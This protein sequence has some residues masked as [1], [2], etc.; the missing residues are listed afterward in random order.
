MAEG[1]AAEG[2]GQAH[3]AQAEESM[4]LLDTDHVTVLRY[5]GHPRCSTL[6]DRLREARQPAATTIVTLEEQMRGWLAE[7][8][9]WREVAKQVTAYERLADLF[10]FFSGW[11][12]IRFDARAAEEF[13]RLRM[14]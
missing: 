11:D 8:G 7:I 12:V 2:T 3:R 14:Q 10:R 13:T 5:V 1:G 9:R 4:I 6:T